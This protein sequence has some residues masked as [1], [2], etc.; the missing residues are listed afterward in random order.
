[1]TTTTATS[2]DAEIIDRYERD[3]LDGAVFARGSLSA[4]S[5]IGYR[6]PVTA[7]DWSHAVATIARMGARSD[8]LAQMSAAILSRLPNLYGTGPEVKARVYEGAAQAVR[9][10]FDDVHRRSGPEPCR[11]SDAQ[12]RYSLRELLMVEFYIAEA[13]APAAICA[14][15]PGWGWVT[16]ALAEREGVTPPLYDLPMV[17]ASKDRIAADRARR[18]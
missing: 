9:D 14:S 2:R 13:C 16:A 8:S 5:A 4:R 17:K 3:L 1:M 15:V 12:R 10:G 11:H 18:G 6:P 7:R